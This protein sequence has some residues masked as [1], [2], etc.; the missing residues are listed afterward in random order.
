[1]YFDFAANPGKFEI[2]LTVQI[3]LISH[4]PQSITAVVKVLSASVPLTYAIIFFFESPLDA[5]SL[6][7]SMNLTTSYAAIPVPSAICN[8]LL[9]GYFCRYCSIN[10][11][12]LF[13][14]HFTITTYIRTAAANET[15][16]IP[17]YIQIIHIIPFIT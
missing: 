14:Y 6:P 4:P 3:Y 15:L 1:M 11:N 17:A 13:C 2:S 9:F 12:W 16:P 7:S 10:V 5:V 8:A